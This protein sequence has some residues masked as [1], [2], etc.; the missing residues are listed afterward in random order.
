MKIA[1][2]YEFSKKILIKVLKI[3]KLNSVIPQYYGNN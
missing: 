1:G 2:E 3:N